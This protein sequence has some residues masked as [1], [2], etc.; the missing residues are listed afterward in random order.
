MS[1]FISEPGT[2]LGGRYRLEDRT[3]AAGGWAAWKAI[4]EILARPVTVVT[5]EPGFPRVRETVTAARAAGRL[6]D[7]RLTQVFDV[8][9]DWDHAYIVMEWAAGDSLDDLLAAGPVDPGHAAQ[10]IAEAAAALSVAHAA[11]LAHLCLQPGSLRWTPNSGVKIVGL[12]VDAAL[13]GITSEDPA[14]D[15]TRGLASLLYATLT[16]HWPGPDC[17]PSLPPAPAADGQA[18]RPRQITAGVPAV[19][20]DITCRAL[21]QQ[22]RRG[23]SALSTPGELA[24]ELTAAIPKAPPPEAAPPQPTRGYPAGAYPA[25]TVPGRTGYEPASLPPGGWDTRPP[26]GPR[27][28]RK[29]P[30]RN[31][32]AIATVL[33]FVVVTA[34]TIGTMTLRGSPSHGHLPSSVQSPNSPSTQ[35]TQVLKPIGAQGVS[36]PSTKAALAID[37][38]PATA[39]STQYYLGNPRFGGLKNGSGLLLDMG[40]T[41]KLSSVTVT[42]GSTPG[43][44]VSIKLGNDSSADP[45]SVSSFTTVAQQDGVPGG[46][47]TFDVHSSASGRYLLIWFTK[48]PPKA[49]GGPS[50]S[51]GASIFN[52]IVN[53]SS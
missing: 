24:A 50:G 30:S 41:V 23:A 18:R 49:D 32:I 46:T 1:T 8:E 5:F 39:W 33:V 31:L 53:G 48:L 14:A 4:D 37:G 3:A 38:S 22:N 19:L 27:P 6:T 11:G 15:D 45:G 52:I 29:R 47:T 9:D 16:G 40:K 20:D 36:E 42:F 35:A 13:T 26:A 21:F 7:A 17:P 10:I 51:F 28:G 34:I 2:R 44:D 25:S 12:G 43:A